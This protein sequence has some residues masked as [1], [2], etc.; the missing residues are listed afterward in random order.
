MASFDA[1][2]MRSKGSA[3]NKKRCQFE[4]THSRDAVICDE[5]HRTMSKHYP[6]ND[7]LKD[8]HCLSVCL[9]VCR[10][11]DSTLHSCS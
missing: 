1:S 9:P 7:H 5:T 11:S 6:V 2:I 8:S 10:C 4:S 3:L